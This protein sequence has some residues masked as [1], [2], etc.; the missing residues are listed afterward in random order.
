MKK[1]YII[2][3]FLGTMSGYSQ[4]TT[5]FYSIENGK[6]GT[7]VI[8]AKT[9]YQNL[10][11]EEREN[12]IYQSFNGMAFDFLQVYY[13]S[14]RELWKKD[15]NSLSLLDSMD[16]NNPDLRK[17]IVAKQGKLTAYPIFIYVGAQ[18]SFNYNMYNFYYNFRFETFL[19]KNHW[20][21]AF[22]LSLGL[23]DGNFSVNIGGASKYYFP[24]KIK[25]HNLSVY[26]GLQASYIYNDGSEYPSHDWDVSGMIGMSWYVGPG[27][28]DFGIQSGKVSNFTTTIGYTFSLNN[29]IKRKK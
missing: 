20:D 18:G 27:S 23:N 29:L 22:S 17:Y 4:D 12:I 3:V 13:G 26:A 1:I 11:V 28:L 15:Q 7:L 16:M 2:I 5:Y 9:A 19:L 10:S 8:H 24:F 14:K 6:N 21:A 25:T